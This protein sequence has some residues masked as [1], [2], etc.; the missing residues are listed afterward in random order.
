MNLRFPLFL[1]LTTLVWPTLSLFAQ[2]AEAPGAGI[3]KPVFRWDSPTDGL[4]LGSYNGELLVGETASHLAGVDPKTG[5]VR[6]EGGTLK[7]LREFITLK[8]RYILIGEHVQVVSRLDGKVL[9]DFPLN[10]FKDGECNA[11]IVQHEG[12]QLLAAGFGTQYNMLMLLD[13][14]EG[15]QIWPSW[16]T[17]CSLAAAARVN[18]VIFTVCSS[19]PLLQAYSIANRTTLYSAPNPVDGFVPT[20]AW[21]GKRLVYVLGT[22]E[23]KNRLLVLDSANGNLKKSFNVKAD[24][25]DPGF[26]FLVAPEGGVFVPW[27]KEG[28][29][30]KLWGLEAE[31]GA[32]LWSAQFPGG[33]VLGQ[34]GEIA[35][36]QS[37]ED[38]LASLTGMDLATGKPTYR[39]PLYMRDPLVSLSGDRLILLS[40]ADRSFAV[41]K[42]AD[43]LAQTVGQLPDDSELPGL[44]LGFWTDGANAVLTAGRARVLFTV[45]PVSACLDGLHKAIQ[46]GKEEEAFRIYRNL[47]PYR[48]VLKE[49]QHAYQIIAGYRLLKADLLLQQNDVP[50]AVESV[51]QVLAESETWTADEYRFTVPRIARFAVHLALSSRK[52]SARD[53]FLFEVLDLFA[54]PRYDALPLKV[55]LDTMLVLASALASGE[56]GEAVSQLLLQVRGRPEMEALVSSH[57]YYLLAGLRRI[58]DLLSKARSL[59]A[60]YEF[61]ACVDAIEAVTKEPAAQLVFDNEVEAWLDAQSVKLLPAEAR[62]D[63]LPDIVDGLSKHFDKSSRDSTRRAREE[64]CLTAC[65]T[66]RS[67]CEVPCVSARDCDNSAR[68]C[69][70]SCREGKKRYEPPRFSFSP[71]DPR[72]QERCGPGAK[73]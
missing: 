55:S 48:S 36:L 64:V 22:A 2:E 53:D 7:S 19:G 37:Q 57:P 35:V 54:N 6:W 34:S 16:L 51:Q 21:Y 11:N 44:P 27:Q 23:G 25:G 50:K 20:R 26:G 69:R 3:A 8:D 39:I 12:S 41:V 46:E 13:A 60:E 65:D 24:V 70:S 29:T 4:A 73:P 58:R 47:W 10:C 56:Y 28:D 43:G 61:L 68:K 38:V 49:A 17:T 52:S 14:E 71:A 67:L 33:T 72:F 45:G 1:L 15:K 40:H 18:K 31:T 5:L 42:V 32:V 59:L 30:L 62:P 9:W 63:Q 66:A